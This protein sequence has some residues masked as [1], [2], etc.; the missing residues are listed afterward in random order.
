MR[1]ETQGLLGRIS[2]QF[3]VTPVSPVE[4]HIVRLGPRMHTLRRTPPQ[5]VPANAAKCICPPGLSEPVTSLRA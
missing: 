1:D 4:G 3:A 2:R 5:A